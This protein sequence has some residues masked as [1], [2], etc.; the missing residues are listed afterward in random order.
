MQGVGQR[1][2]SGAVVASE[3]GSTIDDHITTG[4]LL[5]GLV[6]HL[7]SK[8]GIATTTGGLGKYVRVQTD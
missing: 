5:N 3:A 4:A 8:R 1:T 7:E 6:R 2:P